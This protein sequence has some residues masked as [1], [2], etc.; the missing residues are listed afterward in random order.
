MFSYSGFWLWQHQE[1]SRYKLIT[2]ISTSLESQTRP[3]MCTAHACMSRVYIP[4]HGKNCNIPTGD[5]LTIVTLWYIPLHTEPLTSTRKK[6]VILFTITLWWMKFNIVTVTLCASGYNITSAPSMWDSYRLLMMT[7][8]IFVVLISWISLL[9]GA[10]HMHTFS[11]NN[12]PDQLSIAVLKTSTSTQNPGTA[13]IR[14][15]W[16]QLYRSRGVKP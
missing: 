11:R 1:L 7:M 13:L 14:S 8:Q 5:C 4:H 6:I 15:S 16:G 12:N 2:L 9:A 10:Q 3:D